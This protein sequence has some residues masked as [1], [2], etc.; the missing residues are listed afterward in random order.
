MAS[1]YT[2]PTVVVHRDSKNLSIASQQVCD[3]CVISF[4][5]I[6]AVMFITRQVKS[7]SQVKE[8]LESTCI[9]GLCFKVWC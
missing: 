6:I 1:F 3:Q 7:S 4:L 2:Y 5:H 8:V 9:A